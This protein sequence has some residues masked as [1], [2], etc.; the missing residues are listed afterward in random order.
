M[1]GTPRRVKAPS[2]IS[3]VVA[4]SGSPATPGHVRLSDR[5]L[6]WTLQ[7]IRLSDLQRVLSLMGVAALGA[8]LL[9]PGQGY[10]FYAYWSISPSEPYGVR[11]DF[12]AFRYAPPISFLFIPFGLLPF[13][14]AYLAWVGLNVAAIWYV[15]RG[16]ALALVLFPPVLADIAFGNINTLFAVM[17]VAGWRHPEWWTFGLLTKVTPGIGLVWFLVRREWVALGRVATATLAIV[18]LS[19]AVQ[20]PGVWREWLE[21]LTVRADSRSPWELYVPLMPRMALAGLLV[22]WGG[23]TDRRWVVP[24]AICLASPSLWLSSLFLA[25]LV[26]VPFLRLLPETGS[27]LS[28]AMPAEGR[29]GRIAVPTSHPVV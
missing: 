5:S 14:I 10:D 1:R 22:A 6:L 11:S 16:W 7:P 2:A 28:A 20:G 12:G 9:T 13:S 15:A 18:I 26:A 17:V 23:L 19:V 3:A 8:V 27:D 4:L 29:P 25:P 24:A 21:M